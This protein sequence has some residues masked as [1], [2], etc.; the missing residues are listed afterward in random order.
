MV[1]AVT[2]LDYLLLREPHLPSVSPPERESRD[3]NGPVCVGMD[4]SVDTRPGCISYCTYNIILFICM[5]SMVGHL[6]MYVCV[7]V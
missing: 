6:R 4:R 2:L 7:C 5:M 1:L 3:F